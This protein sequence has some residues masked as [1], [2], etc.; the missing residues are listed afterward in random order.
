[1]KPE[2]PNHDP[3]IVRVNEDKYKRPYVFRVSL[4]SN[5]FLYEGR[6]PGGEC[7][8][9]PMTASEEG[10]LSSQKSDKAGIVDTICR[11]C[12]VEMPVPYEDM[13]VSDSFFLLLYIR[14]VSY[15]MDYRFSLTCPHCGTKFGRTLRVP[16][17]LKA[18]ALTEEDDCEPYEVKLPMSGDVLTFHLL[19]NK[20]E[21]AIRRFTKNRYMKSVDEGDPSYCMRLA[22]HIESINGE[23]MDLLKRH[24]YVESMIVTDSDAFKEA[25]RSRDFGASITLEAECPQCGRGFEDDMPFD[26]EFF[27]S[28][29]S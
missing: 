4:P 16:Q 20:D 23:K 11:R 5:G 13:L 28:V 6:F 9:S 3:S 22:V 24:S 19:R 8:I 18:T 12:I 2:K 25:I 26:R 7:L 15:G 10:L 17:D 21:D 27:R 14:N 1:M 29:R